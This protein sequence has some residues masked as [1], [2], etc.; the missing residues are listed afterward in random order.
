MLMELQLRYD[1]PALKGHSMD[2]RDLAPA[3][4]AFGELCKEANRTLNGDKA[5]IKVLVNA[6]IEANCITISLQVIQSIFES[7]KALIKDD[8]VATAKELLEWIGII[9]PPA[10][11]AIGLTLIGLLKIKR[12]KK[13]ESQISIKDGTGNCQIQ[14]QLKGNNNVIN[15]SPQ[16]MQLSSKKKV[17][18]SLQGIL[19]PVANK[20]G[21]DSVEFEFAGTKKV[22]IGKET[23]QE[24][25]TI[26]IEDDD[27]EPQYL[28][29]HITIY[30]P[31][32]DTKGKIWKF[33]YNGN[34]EAIDIGET[35]IAS[36]I[37][38][39]GKVIVGDTF[40]VKMEVQEKKTEGGYK[41]TYKVIE[42]L[43]FI[44]GEDQSEMRFMAIPEL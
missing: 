44:P 7:A 16:V 40:K 28:V 9:V 26:P 5:A 13:I 11:A 19:A 21:I 12:D 34:V 14:L 24:I 25:T 30:S 31:V 42:V 22:Q 36:D 27:S 43:D 4:L 15:V 17:V 3:L 37:L 32:F 6:D 18:K 38:S 10:K 39:R 35:S 23:A 29:G 1:G 8:N 20:N 41:N 2:V 33:K